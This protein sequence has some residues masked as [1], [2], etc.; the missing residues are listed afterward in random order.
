MPA[1]DQYQSPVPETELATPELQRPVVGAVTNEPPFEYPHWPLTGVIVLLAEQFAVEPPFVPLHDQYQGP[2]PEIPLDVP[3]LH[4]PAVGVLENDPPF[5]YP[6]C[7]LTGDDA[8]YA[9]QFAVEPPLVPL[10]DQYHG[11]V[12]EKELGEP[13]LH[14][15]AVGAAKN[16][17]PLAEPH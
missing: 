3:E 17:L 7:P 13:E 1:H 10:H 2:E 11:P 16:E 6:H 5:E 15:P 8:L 12:P 14:S 9:E 4:S